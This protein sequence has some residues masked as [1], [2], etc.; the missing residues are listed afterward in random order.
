MPLLTLRWRVNI[1]LIMSF[2]INKE[3]INTP[4]K[5]VRKMSSGN[6][7]KEKFKQL[8]NIKFLIL[9]NS[10]L[11]EWKLTQ[12]YA[13]CTCQ[14]GKEKFLVWLRMWETVL[15][16]SQLFGPSDLGHKICFV[17]ICNYWLPFSE[18]SR[19]IKGSI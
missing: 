16:K 17:I 15:R 12:C 14:T 9:L 7:P 13:I 11:K 4:E 8:R 19:T 5:K 6:S 2:S 18:S 1:L 3:N 10:N